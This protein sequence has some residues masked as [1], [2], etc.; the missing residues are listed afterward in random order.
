MLGVRASWHCEYCGENL[1]E[2]PDVYASW[3][4]DH[5][6]PVN[7][8]GSGEL[9]NLAVACRNCNFL[10]KNK[11]DPRAT[12]DARSSTDRDALIQAVRTYVAKKRDKY[13]AHL[14]DVRAV[15]AADA[16][17]DTAA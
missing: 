10:F 1:L 9:C 14:G 11:W 3:Q 15:I 17:N 13:N 2:S 5:I 6:V 7:A 8:G 12:A 16:E 4:V